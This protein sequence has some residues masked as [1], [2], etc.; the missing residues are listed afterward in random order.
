MSGHHK[1][2]RRKSSGSISKLKTR[3]K[4]RKAGPARRSRKV[5]SGKTGEGDEPVEMVDF[6]DDKKWKR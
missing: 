1:Q 5:S 2:D 6:S 4:S 3:L